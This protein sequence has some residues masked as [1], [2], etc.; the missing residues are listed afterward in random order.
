MKGTARALSIPATGILNFILVK[1][2]GLVF[3]VA[4]NKFVQNER[5][6]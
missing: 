2:A 6:R 4:E 5:I 3:E 1:W